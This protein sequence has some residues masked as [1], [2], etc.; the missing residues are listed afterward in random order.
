VQEYIGIFPSKFNYNK[1]L[2]LVGII[3]PLSF[4]KSKR[5]KKD[6]ILDSSF[7]PIRKRMLLYYNTTTSKF[8]SIRIYLDKELVIDI[9]VL[10]LVRVLVFQE[11]ES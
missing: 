6:K 9:I 11:L 10:Y 1:K 8:T 5:I 4:C 3:I 7:F 2:L